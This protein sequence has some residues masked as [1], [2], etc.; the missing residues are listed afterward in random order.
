[1]A[2]GVRRV[3]AM[4]AALVL[5]VACGAGSSGGL[6][7]TERD[8]CSKWFVYV[9][10]GGD[11]LNILPTDILVPGNLSDWSSVEFWVADAGSTGTGP[12]AQAVHDVETSWQSKHAD[13]YAQACKQANVDHGPK[14]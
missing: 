5:A 6:S 10:G 1:V 8:F 3:A 4:L 12:Y 14:Q 7:T 11:K 2:I 13:T 9:V